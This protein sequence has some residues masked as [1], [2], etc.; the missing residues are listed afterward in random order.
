VKIAGFIFLVGFMC[1]QSSTSAEYDYSSLELYD[2]LK[3]ENPW[4]G[5]GRIWWEVHRFSVMIGPAPRR[6]KMS[7]REKKLGTK[8]SMAVQ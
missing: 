3:W 2:L 5:T 1:T 4:R 6:N 7:W 8:R